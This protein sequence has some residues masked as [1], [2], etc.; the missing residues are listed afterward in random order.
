MVVGKGGCWKWC[1]WTS[2][3]VR[4]DGSWKRKAVGNLERGL[5]VKRGC[6]KWRVRLSLT[7]S[8]SVNCV[9]AGSA[10]RS[11]AE[12][13]CWWRHH[14]AP[15]SDWW[16]AG[17]ADTTRSN[18]VSS[19]GEVVVYFRIGRNGK[20]ETAVFHSDATNDEVKGEMNTFRSLTMQMKR[21]FQNPWLNQGL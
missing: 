19:C 8:G 1:D 11:T 10:T 20:Q 2:V 12:I 15:V 21:G 9:V 18:H 17:M 16:A 4:K 6:W 14:E 5:L 13:V 7:N 3:W